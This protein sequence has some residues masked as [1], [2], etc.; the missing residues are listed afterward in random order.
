MV[1]YGYRGIEEKKKIKIFLKKV[2]IFIVRCDII[3]IV[4][5]GDKMKREDFRKEIKR[6]ERSLEKRLREK[7]YIMEDNEREVLR[8][9]ISDIK[10]LGRFDFID[11]MEDKVF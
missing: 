1:N 10:D 6:Y 7:M 3:M 4:K 11:W 9:E 5:G 8:E 2:L